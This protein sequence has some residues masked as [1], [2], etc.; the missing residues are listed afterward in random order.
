MS[1]QIRED[2]GQVDMVNKFDKQEYLDYCNAL[3]GLWIDERH[4][5]RVEMLRSKKTIYSRTVIGCQVI[6]LIGIISEHFRRMSQQWCNDTGF[7]SLVG[8]DIFGAGVSYMLDQL[9][10]S[11]LD[12]LTSGQY[13][14]LGLLSAIG[15]TEPLFHSAVVK[16]DFNKSG[17]YLS[18][19]IKPTGMIELGMLNLT[20]DS[21]YSIE[22]D[23]KDK[24]KAI[25]FASYISPPPTFDGK[26]ISNARYREK[27][28]GSGLT[29][30]I[31]AFAPLLL[32]DFKFEEQSNLRKKICDS[33]HKLSMGWYLKQLHNENLICLLDNSKGW[34]QTVL[35]D[36]SQ[37]EYSEESI[38]VINKMVKRNHV[39]CSNEKDETLIIHKDNLHC[40]KDRKLTSIVGCFKY[41][42]KTYNVV[43]HM[44]LH[45]RLPNFLDYFKKFKS[46]EYSDN[47]TYKPVNSG[48]V[49]I[50][51]ITLEEVENV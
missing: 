41:H 15:G 10:E 31:N 32:H 23:F 24:L 43:L 34:V 42:G 3:K 44:K 13:A 30:I 28:K 5:K 18:I 39:L 27:I 25:T 38:T 9:L 21:M 45:C 4:N 12:K 16:S 26:R 48:A 51:D 50:Y 19:L 33:N 1:F 40:P 37:I 14:E 35:N 17:Q 8:T 6:P 2:L 29:D 22:F 20:K 11:L 46:P 49:H 47:V 7:K 36:D